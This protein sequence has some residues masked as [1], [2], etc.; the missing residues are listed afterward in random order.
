MR[1]DESVFDGT[2]DYY[3]KYR[4]KYP[5]VV[6]DR[7]IEIFEPSRDDVLLDLG[8]G[9]GELALP[10]AKHFG[11]IL[12]WDPN[13]DMLNKAK[14]K[15]DKQNVSNVVFE[16]K[17]SDDLSSLTERIKLCAMGQSFHW[18]NGVGTLIELKKHLMDDGGV[19]II[20]I[21]HGLHIYSTSY[22]IPFDEP[23]AI[24]VERNR[25]V[26]EVVVKYLGAERKAGSGIFE[27]DKKSYESMLS[28]AG[29]FDVKED[30]WDITTKRSID[31]VIGWLYSSS[32]GNKSQLGNK[33][34][35]FERELRERLR[36]LKPDGV[37]DERISFRLLT[38]K[39]LNSG[40]QK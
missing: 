5:R 7:I 1:Y 14:E 9:T 15:A 12:A 36:E 19:A 18:M 2:V 30:V 17:S 20:S 26:R 11:K 32:W 24:T 37:F 35:A 25:V 34:G 13:V 21:R 10:L 6:F 22:T 40:K 4:P 29:F 38:A 33:V 16:Q 27:Q 3:V 39:L 23:S 8:C 31:D 28:E